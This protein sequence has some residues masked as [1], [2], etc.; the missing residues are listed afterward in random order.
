MGLRRAAG[1]LIAIGALTRSI[2]CCCSASL[3]SFTISTSIFIHRLLHW[4]PLYRTVHSLH[5][6]N[7]NV[8]P[9]S[10]LAM[11]PFEHLL[12]FSG[13]LIYWIV[14]SHPIHFLFH[15][16][17]LAF[18]PAQG[19]VGFERVVINGKIAIQTHDYHHY[20]HHK[21]FDATLVGIPRYPW[22]SGS[23]LITM[24]RRRRRTQWTSAS[25]SGSGVAISRVSPERSSRRE[26]ARLA[27][28]LGTLAATRCHS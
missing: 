15:M 12:F 13:V 17:H 26:R 2:V 7:V 24:A 11:H 4:P 3:L 21:Y 23:G 28:I 18:S 22:M 16:Q 25:A 14:P 5:H 1:W 10:G 9:W 6:K 19:H 20:L 27:P 8:G